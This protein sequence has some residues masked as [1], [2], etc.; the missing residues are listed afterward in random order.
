MRTLFGFQANS[1]K[2]S[3]LGEMWKARPQCMILTNSLTIHKGKVY[4]Q[5]FRR[6]RSPVPGSAFQCSQ[7]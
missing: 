5:G 7:M 6:V 1:Q 3:Q 2:G 4:G